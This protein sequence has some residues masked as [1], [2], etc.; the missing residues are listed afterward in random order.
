M[1]Q[2]NTIYSQSSTFPENKAGVYYSLHNKSLLTLE[3][4]KNTTEIYQ[5]SC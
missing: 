3:T 2:N 4:V 1:E 5:L